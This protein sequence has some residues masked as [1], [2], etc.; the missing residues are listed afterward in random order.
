MNH[1]I[2]FTFLYICGHILL[3]TFGVASNHSHCLVGGG[4]G[5]AYPHCPVGGGSGLSHPHCPVGDSGGDLYRIEGSSS[6][7]ADLEHPLAGRAATAS[8]SVNLLPGGVGTAESLDN[9]LVGFH[10]DCDFAL[11]HSTLRYNW[12]Y[13]NMMTLTEHGVVPLQQWTDALNSKDLPTF[14]QLSE[15]ALRDSHW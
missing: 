2:I 5:L 8:L 14:M 1:F 11:A 9:T 12:Q 3:G 4:T 13:I 7:G 6:V 15:D 10:I